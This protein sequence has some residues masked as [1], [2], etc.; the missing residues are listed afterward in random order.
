[1]KTTT[2]PCRRHDRHRGHHH[3]RHDRHGRRDR[4]ANRDH[5]PTPGQRGCLKI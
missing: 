1:M 4:D 3:D 2:S 5:V